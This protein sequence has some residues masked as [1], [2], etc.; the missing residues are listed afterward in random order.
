MKSLSLRH[1]LAIAG[2]VLVICMMSIVTFALVELFERHITMR[3][4]VE[5]QGYQD[6]II[7]GLSDTDGMI[8]KSIMPL[9][10]RFARPYGGLYWQIEN[11]K[12]VF[13]SRS[14]WDYT[15]SLPN[16]TLHPGMVHTH[17]MKGPNE[18]SILVVERAV[19]LSPGKRS[20]RV[21][22]ALN[23]NE[24]AE[25][26][27]M[28]LES[29]LPFIITLSLIIL[30]AQWIQITLGLSP[31]KRIQD[32]LKH[33]HKSPNARMERQW[34]REVQPLAAQL[35]KLLDARAEDL[36][37]ARMRA[38]NLA[39]G[40][41]TPLQALLGE[42]KRIEESGNQTAADHIGVIATTMH[43]HI[44]H[45]LARARQAST[46]D[47]IPSVDLHDIINRVIRVIQRTPK[48]TRLNWIVNI[49]K[50]TNVRMHESELTEALGALLE[51]ATTYARTS[52]HIQTTFEDQLCLVIKDDGPGVPNALIDNIMQRGVRADEHQQGSGLGLSIAN[53]IAH[54]YGG[55]L[56]VTN[57]KT[58]LEIRFRFGKHTEKP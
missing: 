33:I 1:R 15:L 55:A 52:V 57:T 58:G 42:A 14:L 25:A 9:D 46:N 27:N 24:L 49:Q 36:E 56:K 40:L 54:K 37:R 18:Q 21:A 32:R 35:D 5:L 47:P 50:H 20:I 13:R 31:L 10:P 44:D 38:A 34:P 23:K 48:G 26:K 12:E 11:G 17:D 43:N 8:S 2:A 45:E 16:D 7:A 3:A 51:N 28:F 53:E 4:E 30:V 39:H 6:Q 19:T 22:V 41:K 29:M